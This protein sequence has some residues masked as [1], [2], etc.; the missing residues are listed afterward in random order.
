MPP[1]PG[2]P[3]QFDKAKFGLR[4]ISSSKLLQVT[5]TVHLSDQFVKTD[6]LTFDPGSVLVF[7]DLNGDFIAIYAKR[8]NLGPHFE[9]RRGTPTGLDGANAQTLGRRSRPLRAMDKMDILVFTAKTDRMGSTELAIPKSAFL[10]KRSSTM[11]SPLTLLTL[12]RCFSS[13]VSKVARV[14]TV[15]ME[16]MGLMAI[17][18]L[19]QKMDPGVIAPRGPVGEAVAAMAAPEAMVAPAGMVVTLRPYTCSSLLPT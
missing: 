14:V 7:D 10:W 2:L 6:V 12:T 11:A 15:G 3:A 8:L 19:Q 5:G 4:G 9:I 17:K 16:A 13:T 18:V 1:L